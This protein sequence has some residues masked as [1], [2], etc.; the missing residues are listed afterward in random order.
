MD[1]RS[2][3]RVTRAGVGLAVAW[4]LLAGG[5][6]VAEAA[7]ITPPQRCEGRQNQVAGKYA[8]C[9]ATAEK[10]LLFFADPA[11]YDQKR[12]RCG[13]NFRRDWHKTEGRGGAAACPGSAE[14]MDIEDFLD[15]CMATVADALAGGP[16]GLDPATCNAALTDALDANAT[17]DA[18]K[19]VAPGAMPVCPAAACAQ[20]CEPVDTSRCFVRGTRYVCPTPSCSCGNFQATTAC[21][22]P[23]PACDPVC[24][25]PSCGV[26]CE[27]GQ[28]GDAACPTCEGVCGEARCVAKCSNWDVTH[29]CAATFACSIETPTCTTVCKKPFCTWYDRDGAGTPPACEE[30]APAGLID[31]GQT[32]LDC[33]PPTGPEATDWSI[34]C[35]KPEC[36]IKCTAAVPATCDGEARCDVDCT[37]PIC[38][39]TCD[40]PVCGVDPVTG[41]SACSPPENCTT[42]CRC[43]IGTCTRSK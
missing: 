40:P 24:E 14:A 26:S 36:E 31:P 5:A 38:E 41:A 25:P 21:T 19:I 11:R 23:A 1:V 37:D 35:E 10:Q 20:T 6:L 3:A 18:G 33:S 17:C 15:G 30:S 16:L 42:T 8:A 2:V 12:A 43:R 9:L 34:L 28:C 29:P 39:V 27:P 13:A 7:R 32:G 4:V 22:L